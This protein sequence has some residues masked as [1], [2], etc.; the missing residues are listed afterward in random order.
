[1]QWSTLAVI[2][3]KSLKRNSVH[4]SSGRN[5]MEK[6][7]LFGIKLD[8]SMSQ[9]PISKLGLSIPKVTLGNSQRKNLD[10]FNDAMELPD[11]ASTRIVLE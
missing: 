6:T 7:N 2:Y 9:Q 10:G 1:M 5:D 3:F 4:D 8:K 11:E